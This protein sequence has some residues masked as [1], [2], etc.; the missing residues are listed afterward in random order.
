MKFATTAPNKPNPATRDVPIARNSFGSDSETN[1]IPAPNSPAKPTP[2]IKRKAEY[3]TVL[4]MK[5]ICGKNPQAIFA[6]E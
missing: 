5:S 4:S 1:V 3:A 6:K 2:A